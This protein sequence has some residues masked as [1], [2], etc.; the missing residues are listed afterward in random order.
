MVRLFFGCGH[1]DRRSEGYLNV[2]IRNW[3]HVD[4]VC[5]ISLKLPFEDNF[6]DEI[7]AES[8]LEHIRPS[9][10][11]HAVPERC[12]LRTISVLHEWRRVLKPNGLLIVK[13][14]N[15]R[16]IVYQY[17]NNNI[18]PRDFSMYI[19]GGQ[20]YDENTHYTGFD[21]FT[22]HDVM[23][24]AGFRDI[25][26]KNAHDLNQDLGDSATK[27]WEMTGIGVK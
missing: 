26:I 5:D 25:K 14:P 3:P 21:P 17:V 27:A 13:V 4:Y 15:I 11:S 8:V 20:E 2:D 16:G 12:H 9:F 23:Q 1:L 22:L 7:F 10:K 24:S 6:A 18:S 19:Y